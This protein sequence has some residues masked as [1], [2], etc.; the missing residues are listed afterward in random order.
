[1]GNG[2][3]GAELFNALA[4]SDPNVLEV[5]SAAEGEHAGE[6]KA[7][8]SAM[9]SREEDSAELA[10]LAAVI[11]HRGDL[12]WGR[13]A[14]GSRLLGQLSGLGVRRLSEAS[15][16]ASWLRL[17]ESDRLELTSSKAGLLQLRLSDTDVLQL[18]LS[19]TDVLQLRLSDTDVLQM[20][21]GKPSGLSDTDV[22][23]LA[24]RGTVLEQPLS[25]TD[26]LQLRLSDTDVLQV[27]R[28]EPGVLRVSLSDTDV[29]QLRLNGRLQPRQRER[30]VVAALDALNGTPASSRAAPQA[31]GA[32]L[33]PE[34][35]S[36]GLAALMGAF[37]DFLP[38]LEL[39]P[40]PDELRSSLGTLAKARPETL[41]SLARLASERAELLKA[42]VGVHFSNGS[43]P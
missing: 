6:V 25:A 15:R 2:S 27:S 28:G 36:Q 18:R 5:M 38:A 13:G 22:L 37:V 42:L 26:E 11:A 41:S 14:D 19:D 21:L 16:K 29:L 8:A 4:Q 7:V 23:R 34:T 3:K 35:A 10:Q 31:T 17:T 32:E 9:V 12:E 40:L 33:S 24:V 1:M 30:L 43:L 20:R 39:D